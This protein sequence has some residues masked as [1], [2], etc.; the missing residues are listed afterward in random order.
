MAFIRTKTVKGNTY[1]Y[2]VQ[3]Q[4]TQ[5]GARQRSKKYLGRVFLL[6]KVRDKPFCSME[7]YVIK[8]KSKK[9]ILANAIV[10][11]LQG[12]G[13]SQKENKLKKENLFVDLK[14]LEVAQRNGNPAALSLNGGILCTE[15]ISRIL[16][17]RESE[18]NIE[19]YQLAK[20]CVEAGLSLP[21][22]LFVAIYEAAKH[23]QP[24]GA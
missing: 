22:K 21:E 14:T 4:W 18:E 11:T 5:K 3:N 10:I 9:E 23:E 7:N 1:A 20:C 2:L 8:G 6:E 19:G 24:D 13:F 15:T 17:C 12:Y 16:A